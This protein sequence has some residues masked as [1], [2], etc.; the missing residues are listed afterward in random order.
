MHIISMATMK[1][2]VGK[3]TSAHAVASVFAE[4]ERV[5]LVDIDPQATLTKAIGVSHPH[6]LYDVL[7]GTA[8]PQSAVALLSE[9]L[10]IMPSQ[11]EMAEAE[12]AISGRIGRER[13]L[14]RI[15]APLASEFDVAIID[16]PPSLGLLTV[17]A[18]VASRGVVVPTQPQAA[19]LYGLREFLLTTIVQ[20]QEFLNPI[21]EVIGV[22]VTQYM[23]RVNHHREALVI[24]EQA[25]LPLLDAVIPRTV[26]VAEALG[27]GES[28][29]TYQPS[30]PASAAY[31]AVA[32]EINQW[33]RNLR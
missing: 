33:R 21:L 28:I 4:H 14:S 30:H 29:V 20:V 26:K 17:N 3:T 22:L 10:A 27:V 7:M 15:L 18:L 2:G 9:S 19:D 1:G 5:L 23:K 6:T 25:E 8:R 11:I 31:V 32:E 13:L 24:M 12:I 16:T